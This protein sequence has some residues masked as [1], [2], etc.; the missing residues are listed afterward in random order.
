MIEKKQAVILHRTTSTPQDDIRLADVV[1]F[2]GKIEKNRLGKEGRWP[3]LTEMER[4][5][6]DYE[7]TQR[8]GTLNAPDVSEQASLF[9]SMLR[10]QLKR[11]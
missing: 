11:N 1:V 2:G 4:R 5:H 9:G 8:I 6:P 7:F 10:S 3:G